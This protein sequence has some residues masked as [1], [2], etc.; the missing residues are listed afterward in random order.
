MKN[1]FRNMLYLVFG[2]TVLLIGYELIKTLYYRHNLK[3]DDLG[4]KKNSFIYKLANKNQV[5]FIYSQEIATT[6]RAIKVSLDLLKTISLITIS[7]IFLDGTLQKK[8]IIMADS[9]IT[10][11]KNG[12]RE[13]KKSEINFISL[14]GGL[15]FL[16]KTISDLLMESEI[17][18]FYIL[19]TILTTILMYLILIPMGIFLI[20]I[21][22]KTFGKFFIVACYLALII[23]LLPELLIQE[24]VDSEKMVKVDIS[25]YPEDIQDLLNENGL[26]NSVYEEINKSSEKNAALVGYGSKKRLEIYGKFNNKN[27]KALHSV[28]LHEIGH[29][30]ENTFLRKTIIYISLIIAEMIFVIFLY[31]KVSFKFSNETLSFFSAF[32]I[33]FLMYRMVIKQWLFSI[34]KIV[35]QKS[36]I[37]SDMFAKDHSYGRDLGVTLFNIAVESGDYLFPTLFYNFLRSGH[38]PI[39]DRVNYLEEN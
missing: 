2:I 28:L 12:F 7:I 23:K 19:K 5:N 39:G 33:L 1:F 36:E 35:S 10:L 3:N 15:F 31:E 16:S 6:N 18:V 14:L 29:A 27:S 34:Y 26:E 30:N 17:S 32:I 4:L 21:L 11:I 22:F 13:L 8:A 24:D 20:Y 9:N 38:P 37:N 25:S